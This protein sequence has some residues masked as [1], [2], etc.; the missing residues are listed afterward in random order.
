MSNTADQAGAGS[1]GSVRRVMVLMYHAL[2]DTDGRCEG[3]DPHYAVTPEVFAAQLEAIAAH[4]LRAA[5]VVDLLDSELPGHAVALTFDDGHASNALAA[6]RVLARGGRADF[7]VNPGLVGDARLLSWAALRDLAAAGLSIQSHGH[8]HRHLDGLTAAEVRAELADSKHEIEDRLGR[9][10]SLFA[11]PGGRL[12][13]GLFETARA[14]GYRA[15]CSSR[16]DLWRPGASFEVPRF[17][18]LRGTDAVRFGRWLRQ[19]PLELLGR[20]LRW[21]ALDRA[22]QLLGPGGYERARQRLLGRAA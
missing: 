8:R 6:E 18:V 3:A 17:A 4:G 14:L 5:S 20:R 1:R 10:V 16:V 12:A 21:R 13:A 11:P 22:K 15:V 9:P 19:E 2:L 7:F